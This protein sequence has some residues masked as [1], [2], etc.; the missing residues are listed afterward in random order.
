ML[1]ADYFSLN[2]HNFFLVIGDRFKRWNAIESNPP[3][4]HLT[5][6]TSASSEPRQKV[7]KRA[8]VVFPY[9]KCTPHGSAASR[10]SDI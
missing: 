5:S 2:G 1:V 7:N 10:V 8:I 4:I 3:G 6:M 9:R